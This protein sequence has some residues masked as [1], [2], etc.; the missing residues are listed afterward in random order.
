ML[1]RRAAIHAKQAA[2]KKVHNTLFTTQQ[3]AMTDLTTPQAVSSSG[4]NRLARIDTPFTKK[5]REKEAVDM[6]YLSKH[7]LSAPK[8]WTRGMPNPVI[9]SRLPPVYPFK[10]HAVHPVTGE[11][12]LRPGHRQPGV[13]DLDMPL[14]NQILDYKRRI[15]NNHMAVTR[16]NL[17]VGDQSV[18]QSRVESN[19]ERLT[20]LFDDTIRPFLSRQTRQSPIYKDVI[21][22]QRT[23]RVPLP[24]DTHTLVSPTAGVLH[25]YRMHWVRMY[26]NTQKR[27][28]VWDEMLPF[29]NIYDWNAKVRPITGANNAGLQEF[30]Y[31]CK[32]VAAAR[33][34]NFVGADTMAF[35]AGIKK[36]LPVVAKVDKVEVVKI[37]RRKK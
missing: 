9:K 12:I 13:I 25:A 7:E 27:K 36:I 26:L 17:I 35:L 30:M 4:R 23:P 32:G 20:V 3:R 21:P 14:N 37:R 22:E 19:K 31:Y 8:N 34:S 6:D 28:A 10:T 18:H 2:Q 33:N 29:D 11:Y 24:A 1:H 5:L 16:P 15:V